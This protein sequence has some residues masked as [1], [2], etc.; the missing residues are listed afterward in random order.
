MAG[1]PRIAR[2]DRAVVGVVAEIR[3][4][5]REG[6]QPPLRQVAGKGGEGDV[7]RL[8][9]AAVVGT[10]VVGGGVVLHR[11]LPAG[12]QLARAGHRLDVTPLA[13]ARSPDLTKQ[14]VPRDRM[15]ARWVVVANALRAA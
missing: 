8:T 14:V 5:E 2:L 4:H 7:I 15:G 13:P 11:V 10:R 1:Q 3:C 9:G 6:G 12:G